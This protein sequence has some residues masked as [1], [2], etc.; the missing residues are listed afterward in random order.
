[1]EEDVLFDMD[2][3]NLTN[4]RKPTPVSTGSDAQQRIDDLEK[5]LA[6]WSQRWTEEVNELTKTVINTR[7]L[8]D[9]QP[10]I[11]SM[12]QRLAEERKLVENKI[13]RVVG[14]I[15][16]QG[17]KLR[18]D[19]QTGGMKYNEQNAKLKGENSFHEEERG[20]LQNHADFCTATMQTVDHIIYSIKSNMMYDEQ[21]KLIK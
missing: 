21:Y 7:D 9:A 6:G 19:W 2:K 20:I 3:V 17:A 8:H 12:R 15:S 16:R 11:L 4:S 10:K 13:T 18:G 14:I 5:K 1:M